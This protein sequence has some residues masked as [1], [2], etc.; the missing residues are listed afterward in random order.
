LALRLASN[1][2]LAILL[3]Q[4]FSL[5]QSFLF[6]KPKSQNLKQKPIA[7]SL[8]IKTPKQKPQLKAQSKKPQSKSLASSFSESLISSGKQCG[9]AVL[10]ERHDII[11]RET[12]VPASL[13][14]NNL[15]ETAVLH[16]PLLWLGLCQSLPTDKETNKKKQ[17]NCISRCLCP[18]LIG[19]S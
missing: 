10:G 17:L 16:F 8:K 9:T 2:P 12:C 6:Q 18:F 1:S 4:F 3:Q 19:F 11:T 15:G 13:N 7:K 14:I 5:Q